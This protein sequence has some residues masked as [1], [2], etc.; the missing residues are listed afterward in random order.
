VLRVLALLVATALLAAGCGGSGDAAADGRPT[1]VATTTQAADLAREVGGS[2]VRVVGLLAPNAD[3]H[4]H[5]VGPDDARALA[6]AALIVRSGGDL[7]AWL[8]DAI[9][10]AGSEAPTLTLMDHVATRPGDPHWWQD[11]RNG[12]R[13]VAALRAALARA[14][15]GSA[16][17]FA[18]RA[19]AY[20]RRL[21]ALD[22]AAAACLARIPPERRKLVTTHDSLGYFAARYGLEVVGAVIPSLSTHAQAS[23]GDTAELIATIRREGVPAIFAERSVSARVEEAV[24]RETGARI[25]R[26]L[27]A[28]TLGPRGSD[29]AT[30]LASLA[31]NTRAIADGLGAPGC[32][33]PD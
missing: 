17:G 24:A 3:P 23:A 30:Y 18:R 27:W 10:G 4:D 11:P 28:D 14:A 7:D 21:E 31:A 2:R 25:G 1:V 9:A 12:V 33:L 26:A 8:E 13:A 20:S 16:A 29:G 15:P 22:A 19:A 32:R 6:G 5:E